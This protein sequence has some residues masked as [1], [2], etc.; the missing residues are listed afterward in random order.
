MK[1]IQKQSA[2]S[3]RSRFGL[4]T[5]PLASL[6][7]AALLLGMLQTAAAQSVVVVDSNVQLNEALTR[8]RVDD[9]TS[10]ATVTAP[11]RDGAAVSLLNNEALAKAQANV[12]TTG[13]TIAGQSQIPLADVVNSQESRAQTDAM[14]NGNALVAEPAGTPSVA[15]NATATLSKN[16]FEANAT[17]NTG[18]NS[19]SVSGEGS[20]NIGAGGLG[21]QSNQTKFESDTTS[22]NTSSVE[23][24]L[25]G[26][27]TGNQLTVSGNAARSQSVDNR[28]GNSITISGATQI[29]AGATL[30][31][32]ELQNT[33]TVAADGGSSRLGA[34]TNSTMGVR[35]SNP[36]S[37]VSDGTL[38]V[39]GNEASASGQRNL[40][41]NTIAITEGRISDATP[42]TPLFHL[43]NYQRDATTG[44]TVNVNTFADFGVWI[45]TGNNLAAT[46]NGNQSS[47]AASVNTA[48]NRVALGAAGSGS[49]APA[50]VGEL[51][52][53]SGRVV[54]NQSGGAEVD[55]LTR[56]DA[57]IQAGSS[58]SGPAAVN[59]NRVQSGGFGN[60]VDNTF[61][62]LA[63][64][65]DNVAVRVENTQDY[66]A[67]GI[68][69][70]ARGSFGVRAAQIPAAGAGQPTTLTVS[71]N[72]LA[73]QVRVNAASNLASLGSTTALSQSSL[74]VH[75]EQNS[76]AFADATT[77]LYGF[78]VQS[79]SDLTSGSVT[80]SGNAASAQAL[81]NVATNALT[82]QAT[83][84][85]GGAGAAATADQEDVTADHG[86][87]SKQR[88]NEATYAT[89]TLTNGVGISAGGALPTQ[90][91]VTNN[92][93][94]ATA[95]ANVADNQ[96]QVGSTTAVNGPSF[97]L[98]NVQDNRGEVRAIVSPGGA[99]IG[100]NALG[101]SGTPAPQVTVSGNQ[102][103]AGA[104]GN[105]ASNL[106]SVVAGTSLTASTAAPGVSTSSASAGYAV[107]NSQDNSGEVR[108]A[109]APSRIGLMALNAVPGQ[110]VAV[111][112]NLLNAAAYG[113]HA[114]NSVS[115]SALPGQL[116]A[117]AA[118]A[119]SQVNSAAVTATV[120]SAT[121]ASSVTGTG[122]STTVARN[123]ATATAVGNLAVSSMVIGRN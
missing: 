38:T 73:S 13:V 18:T 54:N 110:G 70:T 21:V 95:R 58:L 123:Q 115:V 3:F 52:G 25:G 105:A 120:A 75:S 101:N 22:A 74:A 92:S 12:G 69:S 51:A 4:R 113:N 11:L 5:L 33:Q 100:V 88:S 30:T 62:A 55:V 45:D 82:L 77:D 79:G 60:R 71:D 97:G 85:S 68:T 39:S 10:G 61:E 76:S 122:G 118:L 90:M 36:G 53:L 94:S 29:D 104:S 107:L 96:L 23:V 116:T 37:S 24:R 34:V 26:A 81:Q 78:G 67:G 66:E 117:S 28:V 63:T 49:A 87:F 57:L 119:S 111:T 40:A 86:V 93:L 43:N 31:T 106:L 42:G 59:G 80:V 16:L 47:A 9:G 6:S 48:S 65:V 89:V 19:V 50:P 2:P 56:T 17:S 35:A 114:V 44:P 41:T 46:L 32:L 121:I 27:S 103:N 108:A 99:A 1:K 14:V 112:G 7:G 84:V 72:V 98:A 91:S 15:Q 8:A 102:L 83:T 20:V 64:R 109:V